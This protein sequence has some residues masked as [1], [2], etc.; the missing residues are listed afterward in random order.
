MIARIEWRD[1]KLQI[2]DPDE[3]SWRPTLVPTENPDV[4]VVAP[5]L[6]E[7]GELVSFNR[8]R[9]AAWP[10]CSWRS[11]RWSASV[12]WARTEGGDVTSRRSEAWISRRSAHRP[13]GSGRGGTR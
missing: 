12:P 2:V 6:R 13:C 4:F 8:H 11:P 9:T 10:R 5:G 7:S 3:E 1:G